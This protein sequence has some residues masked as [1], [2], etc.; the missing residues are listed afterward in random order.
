[1]VL[2][3]PEPPSSQTPAASMLGQLVAAISLAGTPNFNLQVLDANHDGLFLQQH[4]RQL[5]IPALPKL[6]TTFQLPSTSTDDSCSISLDLTPSVLPLSLTPKKGAEKNEVPPHLSQFLQPASLRSMSVVQL[7][8]AGSIDISLLHG[9]PLVGKPSLST[10]SASLQEH[11]SNSLILGQLCASLKEKEACL[12]LRTSEPNPTTNLHDYYLLVPEDPDKRSVVL[13][14]VASRDVLLL[15]DEDKVGS[16][17]EVDS[18][19]EESMY[20][21]FIEESLDA[22]NLTKINPNDFEN[23]NDEDQDDEGGG[24]TMLRGEVLGGSSEMMITDDEFAED[25]RVKSSSGTVRQSKRDDDDIED[26]SEGDEDGEG[27]NEDRGFV[28]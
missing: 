25:W 11:R 28:Y 16:E 26:S 1:M 15:G 19:E 4:L 13:M 20:R 3:P 27:E 2:L 17:Q 14:L 6:S 24:G 12:V 21:D 23:W 8:D 9:L 18:V 5:T 10:L 7:V 22:L